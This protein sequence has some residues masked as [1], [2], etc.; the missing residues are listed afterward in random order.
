M[1]GERIE[2]NGVT[3]I[4]DCYNANPEAMRS[5]LELLRDT[6]ARRRIA[7][8][9]EMLELGREAETLHRGI[10]QFAAEQGIHAVIGI[11]GAARFMVDEAIE[12]GIVGQRRAFFRYSGR[13][14]RISARLSAAG[15]CGPVQ[16]F[17]RR[18][19]GKGA[20]AGVSQEVEE[21]KAMR[22]CSTGCSTNNS[23]RR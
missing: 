21:V 10:G 12:A 18:A 2:R 17:A 13:S 5:M 19:G 9:G 7:V 15:R 3:I 20:G 23:I 4:N 16:R 22:R 11:R 14:G 6:P 1:R 8:L